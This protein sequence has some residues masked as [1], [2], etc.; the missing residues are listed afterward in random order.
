[1]TQRKNPEKLCVEYPVIKS[2]KRKMKRNP[3]I[4]EYQIQ[5]FDRRVRDNPFLLEIIKFVQERA[6]NPTHEEKKEEERLGYIIKGHIYTIENK[7]K[8]IDDLNK[9]IEDLESQLEVYRAYD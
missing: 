7:D 2:I 8:I 3:D 5:N 1:M 4:K 6:G 9:K